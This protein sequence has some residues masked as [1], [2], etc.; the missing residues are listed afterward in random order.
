[1]SK[2]DTFVS[3][4]KNNPKTIIGL[5]GSVLSS[6]VCGGAT[7]YGM[8][9]GNVEIPLWAKV[10]I[11]A[12]VFLVFGAITIL[13]T[14]SSGWENNLKV[15]TRKLAVKLGYEN[16]VDLLEQAKEDYDK[17]VAIKLEQEKAEEERK[18]AIYKAQYVAQVNAGYLGSLDD[19][20]AEQKQKELEQKEMQEKADQ[21]RQ[22]A[23]LKS[24]WIQAISS[25]QTNLG[26][27]EWK[28]TI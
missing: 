19:Y 23:V 5:V 25:N 1:M 3:Y 12:V 21:E 27:E 22:E 2:K 10:I 24:Q 16:A 8:V 14:I 7:S 18:I 13:G 4:L 26:F 17:Q 15:E 28:K 9:L 20:I 11:G 6:L